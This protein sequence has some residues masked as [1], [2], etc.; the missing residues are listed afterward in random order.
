MFLAVPAGGYK[1]VYE[2]ANRLQARG[3]QVTV[4]HPRNIA[5]QPG[6]R[7]YVKSR[8]WPLKLHWR[9]Q[10]L[11]SWFPLAPRVTVKLVPDLRERYLPDSDVIIATGFETAFAVNEC[12]AKKGSKFY[13]I[14]HYEDW[15]GDAARVRASWQ[16]PLH[17][18]VIAQWLYNIAVELG[19]EHRASYLPNGLDFSVFYVT[20]PPAERRQPR[21]AMMAHRLAFKGTSYGLE[22]LRLAR[23][24]IPE[25][26]AVLFGIEPR[27]ADLDGWCE[28][29]QL[30][31]AAA[32]REL[33][34]SVQAFLNPSLS[35]GWGLPAM[36]AMA[37]GCA[38][39][40]ADN[41]GIRDFAEAD[42]SALLVPI[43]RADLLAERICEALT[44]ENL[45]LRLAK[46]AEQ[47]IRRFTWE[48]AVT[49]LEALLQGQSPA[50]AYEPALP[51]VRQKLG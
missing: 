24:R 13:F 20:H 44:N 31:D 3:H 1:V 47:S 8:F 29:V 48:K 30:P 7:E 26:Q 12:G 19:E 25:L 37:C 4:V 39:V 28:Y 2:Y 10:P 45:R 16:L 34:N 36:E 15:D 18:L 6:W 38:L 40:S 11:I 21:V 17:K 49:R 14:Q 22:A 5:P 35:E 9:H 27:P 41:Q 33:Y 42:E 51:L 46:N 32:L 43:K 23:Q 50:L